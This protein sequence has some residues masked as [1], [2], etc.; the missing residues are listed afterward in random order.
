MLVCQMLSALGSEMDG[1]GM[2]PETFMNSS[3]LN[4]FN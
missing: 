4:E 1:G 2:M 3:S